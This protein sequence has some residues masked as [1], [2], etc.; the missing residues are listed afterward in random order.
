MTKIFLASDLHFKI[1]GKT[2]PVEVPKGAQ[3]VVL[4]GDIMV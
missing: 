2:G 4:A 1:S 3:I